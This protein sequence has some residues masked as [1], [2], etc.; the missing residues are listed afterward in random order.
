[1]S[2]KYMQ[3]DINFKASAVSCQTW[4]RDEI[5]V[6]VTAEISAILDQISLVDILN[7]LDKDD[8]LN[9]IGEGYVK[10]YFDLVS[11]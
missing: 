5:D 9:L 7:N 2:R 4:N 3:R 6:T 8:V 11:A 1:M 10:H